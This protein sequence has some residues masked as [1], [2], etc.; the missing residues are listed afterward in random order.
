[1]ALLLIQFCGDCLLKFCIT[2]FVIR[3]LTFDSKIT[4]ENQKPAAHSGIDNLL[5]HPSPR[6]LSIPKSQLK[7]KNPPPIPVLWIAP[8]VPFGLC[9][10]DSRIALRT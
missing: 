1:M 8:Q 5:Y 2:N 7:I 6:T 9:F 3:Q 10:Q 4:T